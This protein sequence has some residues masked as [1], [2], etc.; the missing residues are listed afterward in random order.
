M[1]TCYLYTITH[2]E[3]GKAYVGISVKPER[4]WIQ[5]RYQARHNPKKHLHCALAKH[6]PE[7]FDWRVVEVCPTREIA[8]AREM[9]YIGRGDFVY[10]HSSGGEIGAKPGAVA[11]EKIGRAHRG[12]KLS[13]EHLQTLRANLLAWTE[14]NGQPRKGKSFTPEARARIAETLRRHYSRPGSKDHLL[15]Q[16][17]SAETRAKISAAN[18]VRFARDGHPRTGAKLSPE[19]IA[20]MKQT[21]KERRNGV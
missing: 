21:K 11:R 19:S 6:G 2:R 13:A 4:R 8:C 3:S 17:R 10:N 20:K 7:A 5:H 14:K 9:F 15:N 18:K 16:V 12:K 1:P